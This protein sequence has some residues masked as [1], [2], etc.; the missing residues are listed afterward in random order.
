MRYNCNREVEP[1]A[2]F[3][4]VSFKCLETGKSIENLPALI[5]IGADRT[6]IP[7]GLV[8]LLPGLVLSRSSGSQV[9]EAS[10]LGSNRQ[11]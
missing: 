2:P 1:P 4:H 7:G 5:N 9:S 3:V 6:V 11:C 10:L 8:D